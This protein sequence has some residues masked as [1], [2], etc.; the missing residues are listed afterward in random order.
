LNAT[1]VIDLD[2]EISEELLNEMAFDEMLTKIFCQLSLN[3]MS[4]T[5]SGNLY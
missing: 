1:I 4:G 3:A 2:K 5:D